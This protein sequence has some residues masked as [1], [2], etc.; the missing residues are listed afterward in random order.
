MLR[1]GGFVVGTYLEWL[2]LGVTRFQ[3]LYCYDIKIRCVILYIMVHSIV[4]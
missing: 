2:V 1:S 4:S 3:Q